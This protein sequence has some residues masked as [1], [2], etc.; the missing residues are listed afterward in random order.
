MKYE[1][2]IEKL[3]IKVICEKPEEYIWVHDIIEGFVR[4]ANKD[5]IIDDNDIDPKFME[6]FREYVKSISQSKLKGDKNVEEVS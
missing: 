1:T 6:T 5:T 2:N 4:L 3:E